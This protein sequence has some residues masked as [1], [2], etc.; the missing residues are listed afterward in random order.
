LKRIYRPGYQYKEA[1]V[2][3]MELASAGVQQMLLLTAAD[4]R[5]DKIMKVMD[6]QR[7]VRPASK[8]VGRHCSK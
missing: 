4:P 7:R 5:S 1:G 2:M 3:L 8:S 6:S